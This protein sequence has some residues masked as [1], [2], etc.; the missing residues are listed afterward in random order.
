VKR[1]AILI[2]VAIAAA[3]LLSSHQHKPFPMLVDEAEATMIVCNPTPTP[4]LIRW[5]KQRINRT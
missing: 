3:A 2:F 1:A 4:E 5:H